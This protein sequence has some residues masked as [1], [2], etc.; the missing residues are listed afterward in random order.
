MTPEARIKA[1]V[2]RILVD[3][4]TYFFMP[5]GSGYGRA[6]IPDVVACHHGHFIGI[7]CKA[8]KGKTTA[9]QDRELDAIRAHGGTAVIINEDNIHTLKELLDG[10]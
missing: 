2:R 1:Q 6:G 4:A 3:S 9:L 5:P 10:F 7:E 8:G